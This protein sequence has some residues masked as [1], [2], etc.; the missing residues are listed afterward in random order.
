VT[1]QGA[2]CYALRFSIAH[3]VARKAAE[4]DISVLCSDFVEGVLHLGLK[5]AEAI[6]DCG[7]E[8]Y[9]QAEEM[10]KELVATLKEAGTRIPKD[11]HFMVELNKNFAKKTAALGTQTLARSAVVVSIGVEAFFQIK[12][13]MEDWEAG[14]RQP[15]EAK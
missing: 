12:E 10:D 7:V 4:A 1:V 14:E 13:G 5:Q 3:F 11:P 6:Y 2:F 8:S 15:G 9:E